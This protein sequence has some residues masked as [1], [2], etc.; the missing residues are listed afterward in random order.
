MSSKEALNRRFAYRGQLRRHTTAKRN[1]AMVKFWNAWAGAEMIAGSTQ[2]AAHVSATKAVSEKFHISTWQV[3]RALADTAYLMDEVE[4]KRRIRE[5]QQWA[6]DQKRHLVYAADRLRRYEARR[7]E[8]KKQGKSEAH[9][10][11]RAIND[12][13]AECSITRGQMRR[14]LRA[15]DISTRR[16]K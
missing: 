13:A 5:L 1:T 9:A 14:T 16:T 10:H 7:Q 6:T 2:R 3:R 11:M 15:F 12:V 8:L 4:L